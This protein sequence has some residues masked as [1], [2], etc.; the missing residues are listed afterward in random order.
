M[1]LVNL[2]T[3]TYLDI[4]ERRAETRFERLKRVTVA[5]V[6]Q[7]RF[8]NGAGR[9]EHILRFVNA[10]NMSISSAR[11]R[12]LTVHYR[13]PCASRSICRSESHAMA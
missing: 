9:L 11:P 4:G 2:F 1:L 12:P 10:T 7:F 3:N 5:H 13:A 8:D 6:G